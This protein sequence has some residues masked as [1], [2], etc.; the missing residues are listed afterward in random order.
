MFQQFSVHQ[1]QIVLQRLHNMFTANYQDY[2]YWLSHANILHC[3]MFLFTSISL[4]SAAMP[5]H[6]QLAN[7]A[8][9]FLGAQSW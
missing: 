1:D 5:F 2:Y 9:L 8:D 3:A 4:N 7:P 6:L